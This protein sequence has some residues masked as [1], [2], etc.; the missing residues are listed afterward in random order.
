VSGER[1]PD[2][3]V[4]ELTQFESRCPPRPSRSWKQQQ[5]WQRRIM[6]EA[7]ILT[8]ESEVKTWG[9]ERIDGLLKPERFVDLWLYRWRFSGRSINL[10]VAWEVVISLFYARLEPRSSTVAHAFIFVQS[11]R[12]HKARHEDHR[13]T[14]VIAIVVFSNRDDHIL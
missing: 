5:L 13:I 11:V 1:V 4:S 2:S 8:N 7:K 14:F 3:K 6:Q 10:W 9:I 12:P